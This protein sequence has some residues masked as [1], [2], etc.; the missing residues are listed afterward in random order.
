MGQPASQLIHQRNVSLTA[1]DPDM[2]VQAEDRVVAR[3]MLK[4]R[5]Q[6]GVMCIGRDGLFPREGSWM[7]PR[8]DQ[9][10][11]LRVQHV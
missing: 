5:L 8:T 1:L 9:R 2:D 4:F 6:L 3:D 11:S 7:R 10:Q